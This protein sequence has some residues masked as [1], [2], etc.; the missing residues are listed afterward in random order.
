MQYRRKLGL[1]VAALA[2][3]GLG[4]G[5]AASPAA[6][7]T[8]TTVTTTSTVAP[9]P[10]T[11]T[12]E[13]Y[14]VDRSGF[15]TAADVKTADGTKWVHFYPGAA[16]DLTTMYPVGSNASLY[17]VPS[18][19]GWSLVGYG[20][21][22][23]VPSSMMS[24][25]WVSGE[26]LLKATPYTLVGAK[27]TWVRGKLTGYISDKSGQ[28]LALIVDNNTLVR[29]PPEYR[30]GNVTNNPSTATPLFLNSR[31]V[32]VGYPEAPTYGAVSRFNDRLIA[33]A[34]T[35]NGRSVGTQGFGMKTLGREQTLFGFNIGSPIAG[36]SAHELQADAMGY[37][38]Y[39]P[40]GMGAGG[41]VTP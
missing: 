9:T 18:G 22:M 33:S 19:W 1:T 7:D 16:K 35:V 24:T 13:R 32:A 6:A 11:G 10:L 34:I 15:V 25:T 27:E 20:P 3:C 17:V 21:T 8:M 31:V 12:I 37:M 26:D 36:R 30:Q 29:I 41:S 5:I 23:P 4:Y 14:Y 28:V 40:T 39:T 38:T 2:A